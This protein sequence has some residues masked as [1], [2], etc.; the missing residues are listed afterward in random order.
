[1]LPPAKDKGYLC[2]VSSLLNWVWAV[3]LFMLSV[4][5]TL[6]SFHFGKHFSNNCHVEGT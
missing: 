4:T 5:L 1:M 2:F 3:H 6:T